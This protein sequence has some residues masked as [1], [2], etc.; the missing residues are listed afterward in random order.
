MID[1][2]VSII[3]LV[4]SSTGVFTAIYKIGFQKDNKREATY[5]EEILNPFVVAYKKNHSINPVIFLKSKIKEDCD[6]IPK[7]IFLL[8]QNEEGEN[9]KKVLI[10]DYCELYH[11][12]DNSVKKIFRL[13]LKA[14]NYILILL[15]IF[16]IFLA[17]KYFVDGLIDM[18]QHLNDIFVK[19]QFEYLVD[20]KNGL[21]FLCMSLVGVRLSLLLNKDRYTINKKRVD[22]IIN[23]DVKIYDKKIST[24]VL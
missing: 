6:F 24:I 14:A 17:G 8:V 21:L 10:C 16:M 23:K 13:V 22:K 11:N 7:Y 3:G 4:I 15:A 1:K 2:L 20:C 9:L 19:K 18:G 12:D 5:Y